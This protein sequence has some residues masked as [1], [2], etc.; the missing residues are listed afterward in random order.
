MKHNIFFSFKLVC[1]AFL[2]EHVTEQLI[3]I[4]DIES[5]PDFLLNVRVLKSL[6]KNDKYN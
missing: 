5:L 2:I 4:F 1:I 6:F 3:I